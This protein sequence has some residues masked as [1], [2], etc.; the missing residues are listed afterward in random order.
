MAMTR[1]KR[2]RTVIAIL[3]LIYVIG[4]LAKL[5]ADK[6]VGGGEW[7]V[8]MYVLMAKRFLDGEG[9]FYSDAK[10]GFLASP[11][12]FPGGTFIAILVQLIFDHW[13]EGIMI[14]I[15]AVMSVLAILLFVRIAADHSQI[16]VEPVGGGGA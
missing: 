14:C 6:L 7:G 15:A 2:V 8:S 5:I 1:T 4:C 12:Y 9:L 16:A 10:T 11:F 13:V 3:L